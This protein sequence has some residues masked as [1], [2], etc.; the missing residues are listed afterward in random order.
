MNPE[1]IILEAK[2]K[3]SKLCEERRFAE[4]I[5]VID[6]AL[7]ISP[8]F[9]PLLIK[10]AHIIQ[11]LNDED[12]TYGTLELSKELLEKAA[13]LDEFAVYPKIELA[14]FLY[15]VEDNSIDG[16]EKA[17][18]AL[19]LCNEYINECQELI[20]ECIGEIKKET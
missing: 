3:V 2:E 16:L 15:A 18:K 1:K 12:A 10:K 8:C 7:S 4:A 13:M 20:A 17:E 11:L 19:N 5:K 9:V 6:N 14:H